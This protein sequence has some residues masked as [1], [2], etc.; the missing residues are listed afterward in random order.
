VIG[1]KQSNF[2]YRDVSSKEEKIFSNIAASSKGKVQRRVS[3]SE[4][5]IER[6]SAEWQKQKAAK[7][8]LRQNTLPTTMSY[9]TVPGQP[10]VTLIAPALTVEAIAA[11]TSVQARKRRSTRLMKA[12]SFCSISSE[13]D[14]DIFSGSRDMDHVD[15]VPMLLN[16]F[17]CLQWYGD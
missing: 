17:L 1:R 10:T 7:A 9:L 12:G 14:G 16:F 2:F 11:Q 13:G 6:Q 15:L 4:E 5:E 3:F 8:P